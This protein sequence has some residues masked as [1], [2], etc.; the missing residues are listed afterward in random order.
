MTSAGMEQ[1]VEARSAPARIAVGSPIAQLVVI[2]V[3]YYLAARLS[4]VLRVQPESIAVF[5]P[6][7]GLAAGALI[8][9]GTTAWV[10]V[11]TAVLLATVAANVGFGTPLAVAIV[12]GLCNA[13]ECRL[14]ALIVER[15]PWRVEG[16]R[17]ALDSLDKVFGFLAAALIGTTIAALP[18][19]IALV[20]VAGV[21]VPLG[22]LWMTWLKSDAVGVVT[23]APLL[24]ALPGAVR[25]RLT[26]RRS[27]EGLAVLVVLTATALHEFSS[28]PAE[29]G[30]AT[31]ILLGLLFPL[32]LWLA[33]RCPPMFAATGSFVIALSIVYCVVN[34]YGALGQDSLP[35][36][37]RI[38]IAQ[39]VMV[40]LSM[41]ALAF[42]ALTASQRAIEAQLRTKEQRLRI[43]TQAAGLGVFEWHIKEDRAVWENDRMF[44]LFGHQKSDGALSFVDVLDHYLDP[45]DKE[46]V[47]A[48]SQRSLLAGD[49]NSVIHVRRKDGVWRYIEI[50][51][52]VETD[53]DSHPVRIVGVMTDI[54]DRRRGEEHQALLIA[55]LDHRVKNALERITSLITSTRAE[56]RDL[57]GFIDGLGGRIHSMARAHQLL[58]REHWMGVDLDVLA[59]EHLD[60]HDAPGRITIAGPAIKLTAEATQALSMVLHELATN[61][62]KYGALSSAT[63]R[64]AV[65]WSVAP[66]AVGSPRDILTLTWTE[67]GGPPVRPPERT[68][69]G[70]RVIRMPV[71]YELGGEVDLDFDPEGVRCRMRIPLER[72]VTS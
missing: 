48:D 32:L 36:A 62:A 46:R 5:W 21:P 6:A 17:F 40:S 57:D 19:A 4:L 68:G 41:C 12:F 1:A 3:G 35:L 69:F 26:L 29:A 58:S 25:E 49:V 13:L 18:A 7:S 53:E 30:W 66:A 24:I 61:A 72:L 2:A 71:V 45:S 50:I 34:G 8:A 67:A 43:A 11:C 31:I 20:H 47:I 59:K 10:R 27:L 55:E 14:V 65:D 44:E 51:G 63:G 28:L 60:A 22:T 16:R 54:T 38:F 33:V 56:A 42:S 9:L 39:V 70:T 15:G 23:L 37:E 52:T 64:V